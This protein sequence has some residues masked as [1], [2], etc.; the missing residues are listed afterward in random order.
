VKAHGSIK[1]GMLLVR[2]KLKMRNN[3]E[4]IRVQNIVWSIL[5][6]LQ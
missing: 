1:Y 6:Q 2:V 3:K 4:E 5:V